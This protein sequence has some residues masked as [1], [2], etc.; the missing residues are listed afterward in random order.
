MS[1]T[2]VLVWS[3]GTEPENTYPNGINST[4]AEHLNEDSSIVA[5]ATG[6]EEPQQGITMELLDWADV[7]FWW[8]H[9]EHDTVTDETVDRIETAVRDDGVGFIALHSAHYARPFKR[10][11]GRSGDLGE[12]RW[13]NP[14]EPEIIEIEAP[15]HPIVDGVD[16]F[17][18]PKTEMFGEPFD[19]PT[20]EAVI[21]RSSFPEGGEFRSGVTF[22]FGA[23]RGAYIR[24]GHETFR[25]Y[26]HP[27]IRRIL[28]N[29]AHWAAR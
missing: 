16:D 22:E 24:P 29:T 28:Q 25:L 15:E 14:G 7:L 2:N 27:T 8:G 3:E 4:V 5:K 19:I 13:E 11:I 9:L 20:P 26:H 6:L 18:L 21:F 17:A 12:A 23:G 1:R 10:L